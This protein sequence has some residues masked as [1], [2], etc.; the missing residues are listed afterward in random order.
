MAWQVDFYE[1]E[2]G[3]AP[4]EDFL[5]SLPRQ[6][7]AKALALIKLL[8]ERGASL[9]FPYSSQIRGR[10][11]ELRTRLGKTRLRILYFGDSRRIFILLH[12]IVKTTDRLPETD[13]QIAE[14]RMAGHSQRLGRRK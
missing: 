12:G 4:V 13:I 11:R 8:E 5:D 6:Q 10:L 1:E 7:K 2:D 9:P 14:Q 3:N